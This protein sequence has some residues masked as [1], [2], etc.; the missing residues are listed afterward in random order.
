[1]A[2]EPD[3]D[4]AVTAGFA[5]GDHGVVHQG[6]APEALPQTDASVVT[7]LDVIHHLDDA[8]LAATLVHVCGCLSPGGKLV[9]R[10]TVPGA[11][12]APFY[13][14]Y[15]TQRLRLAG[16]APHYRDRESIVQAMGGA[17]LRVVL[18][19]PTAPG[20]EETWFIGEAGNG[21]AAARPA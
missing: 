21:K 13:R 15:E 2:V 1:V 9:L 10:T 4:R 11:G 8:G 18:V 14:W 3:E 19:Q 7:C 6:C 5:L 12:P 17:G 20:R 16:I